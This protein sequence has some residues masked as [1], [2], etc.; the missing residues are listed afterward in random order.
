MKNIFLLIA[1]VVSMAAQAQVTKVYL[2]ASGLT[3][4]MCSNAINKALK[5]LDFVD[6]VNANL[7]NYTFEISFIQGRQV[8]F[9]K[10]KNKVEGAG[11]YV[12]GFIAKI[13]FD[14]VQVK[15]DQPV[16]VGNHTLFFVNLKEHLL[17]GPK[18]V[19]LLDKGFISAREYKK[20]DFP[21]SLSQ[22]RIYHVTL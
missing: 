3:C 5:S 11:F 16:S 20:Y 22:Q 10:I 2:Q 21:T 19:R 4:S 17:N 13:D 1:L 7:K 14:S 15:D 6:S 9:D 18:P 8:D 12:A